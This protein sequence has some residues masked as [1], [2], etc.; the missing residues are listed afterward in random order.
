MFRP[1]RLIVSVLLLVSP[2]LLALNIASP[3][4]AESVG[5]AVAFVTSSTDARTDAWGPHDNA[6]YRLAQGQFDAALLVCP[7]DGRFT[8]VEG[9]AIELADFDVVWLHQGDSTDMSKPVHGAKSLDALHAYAKNGGGLFLSGAAMAMVHDLGIE[10]VALRVGNVGDDNGQAAMLPLAGTH[11]VFDGL[12]NGGRQIEISSLGHAAF[13]D[14][15]G[16]GG[17]LGGM[18]LAK[19]PGGSE[20]PLV[21]YGV[22]DGR[23][24]TMGW[25]LADYGNM[26]NS[27]YRKNLEKLTGNIVAYLA[28]D[29]NRQKIV[30]APVPGMKTFNAA[31]LA[32]T[33]HEFEALRL[34]I[35]DLTATFPEQYAVGPA[36]RERID[37]LQS[38]CQT[39]L[40]TLSQDESDADLRAEAI[41]SIASLRDE[42]QALQQEA[43][44]AN[45]LLDFERLAFIRRGEGRL[46]LPANWQSNSSLSKTGYDNELKTLEPV[47]PNGEVKTLFQP[48]NG[49]FVGDIKLHFDAKRMLFSMPGSNGRW[50]VH[51]MN[52]DGTGLRELPLIG[53]SDVDNYDACYLPD[54]RIVFTSTAPF[55]GVPCVRGSSHVTNLYLWDPEADDIRQ[56]SVDQEHNWCPTVLNNGRLLYQRWEYTDT[57]HAF[58][59]LLFHMNPDGT[60]QTEYYGSNSYWPNSMFYA[61]PIPN[62]P[63][64]VV[65]IVGGHHDNPRMGELV[66]LDP[67]K[68]RFEA[69]G[70]VQRIP[71]RGKDVEPILLDGLTKNSWP[72]FLHP[73]PLS[74]KYFLV[75]CKPSQSE[76]WGIYVA[77]VFDNIVK[78]IDEPGYALFE[79]TPILATK[80]PPVLPDRVDLSRDDATVFLADVHEGPGLRGVPRGTIKALRLITYHFS[81]Q[82]MGGQVDRVGL[83]GPWDVKAVLGTVP[84]EED[85]SAHFRI[86]ANTPVAVQPLDAEGK[87][88]QLMRSWFTAMPGEVVSCVGCH[89]RQNTS[90]IRALT[91]AA[92][93]GPSEIVP[94]HGPTRGFSY[95]REVQPV[96][97]RH[98][99]ACHDG[100]EHAGV[101]PCDLRDGEDVAAGSLKA[102]YNDNAHF[103]PSYMQLK[104]FVRG[105]TIESDAH[106]LPPREFHADTT[107]LVQMLREGHYGVKLDGESW[108]RLITWIDLN[109]PAHGT[110][111]ETCSGPQRVANQAKRRAELRARYANAHDEPEHVFN[112]YMGDVK[113]LLSTEE[114]GR[115]IVEYRKQRTALADSN[116]ALPSL[117][118]ALSMADSSADS[119]GKTPTIQVEVADGLSIDLVRIPSGQFIQ[120]DTLEANERP[121]HAKTVGQDFWMGSH[122][123]SNALYAAFDP[124][125]DSRLE[126]GDF[127]Q[128]SHQERGYPL[129]GPDQPVV[130]VSWDEAQA[131]C[132]WLSEKTGR[133]FRLPTE[134]EWEYACRAGSQ[135]AFSF[136][137]LSDDFSQHANMS[138]NAGRHIGT[139]GWSLPSGAIPPWRP[140]NDKFDDGSRVSASVG[141]YEANA[142][143]LYDMHGNAAEWTASD[144]RSY[145]GGKADDF[146]PLSDTPDAIPVKKVVRGGSW[147][148]PPTECRSA[149]R[150]AYPADYVVFNVGFR[151][152]CEDIT[153]A[154]QGIIDE[155]ESSTSLTD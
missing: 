23:V 101:T 128:F 143:G 84:V 148:D 16:R 48:E 80:R 19:T 76:P 28:D 11:P 1:D 4:R 89:E 62:H 27:D 152:V 127:L 50:Q 25:R 46:G 29:D 147:N 92:V 78:V 125:H 63:T 5:P 122:E 146:G 35:D 132:D 51:E 137:A 73:H 82:G 33:D 119:A 154:D 10:P 38:R 149:S 7:E 110:W 108:D 14:F 43:L 112:P 100:Q 60:N 144:Y 103:P 105:H 18:L 94:W 120:G 131:F 114:A 129:N 141:S 64:Q 109:T 135:G 136:G 70:V 67:A 32:V 85:G 40:R 98:C 142:W 55:V 49:A 53:E 151:V 130:R 72:K 81:Y 30:V 83:D 93:R 102:N 3:C 74:D 44:L 118:N 79:P 9:D 77:D 90:P 12:V 17:P 95:R 121:A 91:K 133:R 134:T 26:A 54:E 58:Y 104:R 107:K 68:G 8:T 145:K 13:A 47:A 139:Y 116:V 86:P 66:I 52:V 56:L 61:R 140:A 153:L 15:H 99:V 34:A 37:E 138:D 124:T 106:L 126:H 97:D 69:D 113:P 45:P 71:G 123:V 20:N 155:D 42:F 22:G 115:R 117:P 6:A 111:T 36:M 31:S 41:R 87:A 57:P 21:E 96:L 2:C 24:I 59:R 88:V 39:A 65:T 150:L 75:S